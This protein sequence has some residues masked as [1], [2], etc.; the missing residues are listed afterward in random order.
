MIRPV[1]TLEIKEAFFNIGD[2]KSPGPDGY[3]AAFFKEGW[4]IVGDDVVQAV[5]EFFRTGQMLKD[6]NTTII[7]LLPK[8]QTPS[9]VNDYRPISCCNVV[10][11]GISKIIT[12]RI[13]ASLEEVVSSNQSAFLPGRRISDNILLTQELMK[14]YHLDRGRPRSAFKVDIQKA[15]DTVDWDFLEVSLICFGFPR[16]MVKWIMAC[17]SS[18]SFSINVNGDLHG[19]FRGK[20]GLRQDDLFIFSHANVASVMVIR[21]ALDEFKRCSGLVPSLPKSTAF[22]C[23]VQ[24]SM[25]NSILAILP[26]EEGRLP[27]RYLGV[28]LVSSRLVYRDCKILVERVKNK[29][30]NWMNKYLSFAGRL[31]LINSVLTAMQIYWC[32]VFI[33][34]DM[35]VKDI[36]KLLRGFLWCQ[37][38]MKKGKAKVK[39]DDVCMPKEEG[40]LGIKRLKTWNIAL[41]ASHAWHILTL[42]QSIWVRWSYEYKLTSH[43]FWSVGLKAGASWSWRKILL[44]RPLIRNYICC[45]VGDGSFGSAWHDSWSNLGILS[46]II[47]HNDIIRAGW[48]DKT[49]IRDIVNDDGVVW[50]RGWGRKYPTLPSINVPSLSNFPD[51]YGWKDPQGLVHEFSVAKAWDSLRP[52]GN[53]VPWYS[54][55]WYSHCIPRHAFLLWLVLG[56]KLKTQDKLKPWDVRD[57]SDLLCP[58]C[59]ICPDSHTHLFFKCKYSAVVWSKLQRMLQFD[60][61]SDDWQV[62]VAKLTPMAVRN[63]AHVLVAKLCFA[64]AVYAIWQERNTLSFAATISYCGLYILRT[65]FLLIL[66]MVWSRLDIEDTI[67]LALQ[68]PEVY[69]E[70]ARGARCKFETNRTRAVLFEGPPGWTKME[71]IDSLMRKAGFD[72]TITELV[73]KRISLT[74]YQSTLFTMHYGDYVSY[75]KATRGA[76]PSVAGLKSQ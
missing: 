37:G 24:A 15:Y 10:Y 71:A 13:K 40:G 60:V 29:V 47:S 17:V 18:T 50:P 38:P 2:S 35:I 61:V 45:Q 54:V 39:W 69:D 20:R 67:L 56:E 3:S 14:N 21:E 9:R 66:K 63:M 73:R 58:L 52:R 25:K 31:Q 26:F 64:G 6:V 74:R 48:N 65:L 1:T 59:K 49:V 75:V 42:K 36:E 43:H 68:S 5:K 8:V 57:G 30:G 44:I 51:K 12:S 33:L 19:F 27:V 72:G 4:D 22:F 23:N 34:P 7:A 32:S 76:P 41:M 46:N 70:I 16:K 11:K 28:P 55:V 62:I 53:Q